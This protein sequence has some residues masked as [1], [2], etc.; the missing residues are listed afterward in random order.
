MIILFLLLLLLLLFISS[1]EKFDDHKL[2]VHQAPYPN[3]ELYYNVYH[4]QK[5]NYYQDSYNYGLMG[6]NKYNYLNLNQYYF[7]F[8]VD[9]FKHNI[10]KNNYLQKPKNSN[11]HLMKDH[12]FSK[13]FSF[14]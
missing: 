10:K 7:D 12:A 14:N 13:Y 4:P 11:K 1:K 8:F 6:T 3:Q 5:H 2:M 9:E